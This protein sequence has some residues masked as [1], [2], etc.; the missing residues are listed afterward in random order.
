LSD[1]TWSWLVEFQNGTDL[2]LRVTDIIAIGGDFD[3]NGIVDANDLL[4]WQANFGITM[5]ANPA[6]GDANGDG[7]VNIQDYY[8][9]LD[10]VGGAPM[11]VPGGLVGGANAVPEPATVLLTLCGLGVAAGVLRRRRGA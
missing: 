11:P 1:P 5:G 8:I 2:V 9:W 4:V 7:A 10:Q 6:Q 3:G